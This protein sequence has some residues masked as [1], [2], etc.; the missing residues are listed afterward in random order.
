MAEIL[1]FQLAATIGAMGEFSG[2][3]HRG[4]IDRP[5]HSALVGLMAA[6]LGRRR[7]ADMSDLDAR[8][9]TVATF[10]PGEPLR[11][12][13]TVQTIPSAAVKAPQGRPEALRRAGRKVRTTL[14]QRDYRTGL[15]Y[16]VAVEGSDL[17]VIADAL[18]TPVLPLYFGRKAC[19]L[20]APL[21]PHLVEAEGPIDALSHLRLPPWFG[22]R[23]MRSV[24]GAPGTLGAEARIE[25]RQDR[26]IDRARWHFVQQKV[27]IAY[28]D[29]RA[30]GAEE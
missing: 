23:K 22:A 8:P 25:V 5:G 29:L 7:D 4:T 13:H 16:G 14:T 18:R 10:E 9:I 26:A 1:I 30:E 2:H 24:A 11:D 17:G 19:P 21:D 3:A 12:Y 6:A 20:S 15:L 28:P 27:A